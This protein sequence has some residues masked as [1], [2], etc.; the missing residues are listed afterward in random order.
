MN[1]VRVNGWSAFN[2]P[3]QFCRNWRAYPCVAIHCDRRAGSFRDCDDS[4]AFSMFDANPVLGL[5]LLSTTLV[6]VGFAFTNPTLTASASKAASARDMGGSLGFMQGYGSIGQV[7]GLVSAGPF[8]AF[9]GGVASFGFG[10][11]VTCCLMVFIL[12]MLSRQC[13]Q[14]KMADGVC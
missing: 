9:G 5:I 10:T 12:M 8:Y 13:R 2:C 11:A 14:R 4:F 1:C 6:C 3:Y 7:L